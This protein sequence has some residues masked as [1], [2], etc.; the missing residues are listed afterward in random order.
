MENREVLPS[1]K[2][3]QDIL[4][5]FI[6]LVARVIVDLIPAISSIFHFKDVVVRHLPHHYS[7][8]MKEKSEQV[9]IIFD[10][11]IFFMELYFNGSC[12]F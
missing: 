12:K 9:N 10:K 4:H 2:D 6:P 8:A 11:F 5:G 1:S 7:D 3:T